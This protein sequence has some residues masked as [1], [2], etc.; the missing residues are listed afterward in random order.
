M[1]ITKKG[2]SRDS[3][4]EGSQGSKIHISRI[5]MA[6]ALLALGLIYRQDLHNTPYAFAEYFLFLLS[7]LLVGGPVVWTAIKNIGRGQ[8]FDEN[9]L[10]TVATAGAFA[11]HELP[12]GVAVMLFFSL[13]EYFQD[14]AV[15]RS[16]SSITS[17]MDIRPDY[18]NLLINDQSQ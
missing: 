17:L 3:N 18:A 5:V 1:P 14:R 12:E 7:Y 16:R 6:T 10:M 15:N 2:N 9:F 11:I 13:G 8:V 4:L